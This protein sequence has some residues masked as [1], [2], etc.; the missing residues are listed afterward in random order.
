MVIRKGLLHS[1]VHKKAVAA[2]K[3]GFTLE[4]IGKSVG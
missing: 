3:K 2:R 1:R 4:A